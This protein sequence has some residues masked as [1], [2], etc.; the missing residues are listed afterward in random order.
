MPHFVRS[1]GST[2]YGK[3]YSIAYSIAFGDLGEQVT[4]DCRNGHSRICR[5]AQD[6]DAP[7]P[8]AVHGRPASR[9]ML[10]RGRDLNTPRSRGGGLHLRQALLRWGD[11][12][13]LIEGDRERNACP[14]AA[15]AALGTAY[16][17]DVPLPE[18]LYEGFFTGS[19]TDTTPGPQMAACRLWRAGV[20]RSRHGYAPDRNDGKGLGRDPP[21]RRLADRGR[22][23]RDRGGPPGPRRDATRRPQRDP[24]PR[25]FIPRADSRL[26][27]C[28]PRSLLAEAGETERAIV[29]LETMGPNRSPPRGWPAW[30]E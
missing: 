5:H 24:A 6:S 2:D 9:S 4:R 12:S 14:Q 22:G 29:Y 16:F 26:P 27:P 28:G 15:G 20:R 21:E 1:T 17:S 25:S 11:L 19:P 8:P 13:T 23:R 3:A 18:S 7:Q 10:E 30:Y